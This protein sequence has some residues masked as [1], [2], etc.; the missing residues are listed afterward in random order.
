MTLAG[1]TRTRE[2]SYVFPGL[3]FAASMSSCT[4][5]QGAFA[6]TV[7]VGMNPARSMIGSKS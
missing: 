6:D 2:T 5:F 3:A 4:V 7:T 1:R